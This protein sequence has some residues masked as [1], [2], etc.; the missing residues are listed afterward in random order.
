MERLDVVKWAS[1]VERHKPRRAGLPPTGLRMLL[2]SGAT[3]EQ[4]VSVECLTTGSAPMSPD[5]IDSVEARFRKPL[6]YSY[7]ATELGATP[8]ARWTMEARAEWKDRKRGSV[9]RAVPEAELR[10]VNPITGLP[11]P[12][13]EEGLL[14]VRRTAAPAS[15]PDGWIRTNDRAVIDE[16]GFVFIRG[17]ADDVIIRG[18]FKVAPQKV[19]AAIQQHDAVERAAVIG[20]D[21]QRLGQVPVAAVVLRPDCITRPTSAELIAWARQRLAPY[22]TPTRIVVVDALPMTILLKVSRVELQALFDREK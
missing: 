9:G 12:P 2:E 14:E 19:Q 11:L 21:D 7:G 18:G 1:L 16:D 15:G 5:E 20:L 10:S 3:M 13:G 6:L 4:F 17:R 22:E 8:V